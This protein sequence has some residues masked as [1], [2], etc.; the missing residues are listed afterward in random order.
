M[1]TLLFAFLSLFAPLS[2]FAQSLPAQTMP[3]SQPTSQELPPAT[4]PI[5]VAGQCGDGSLNLNEECDDGNILTSDGCS[6]ACTIERCGDRTLQGGRGEQCDDGN[7]SD[8]DGCS[9][10]CS[11]EGSKR[12]T[13]VGFSISV[14]ATVAGIPISRL[15]GSQIPSLISFG[16]GPT[17]GQL[18]IRDYRRAAIFTGARAA[19]LGLAGAGLVIAGS[20]FQGQN[21]GDGLPF[22]AFP[23]DGTFLLGGALL[24]GGLVAYPTVAII[25]LA[26]QWS[27]HTNGPRLRLSSLTPSLGAIGQ[28]AFGLSL[29]ANF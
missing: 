15:T 20:S 25:D 17:L 27:G 26:Q 6:N 10:V 23:G 9:A 14:V 12:S 19:V 28:S 7:T 24:I 29:R 5:V 21:V 1:K 13:L 3:A 11:L 18:Y 8:G 16:I 4:Q 22:N 2:I